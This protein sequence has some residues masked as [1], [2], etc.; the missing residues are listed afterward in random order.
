[1]DVILSTD[2]AEFVNRKVNDGLFSQASDVVSEALRQ[3][4]ERDL[5]SSL[6]GTSK[7]PWSVLGLFQGEDVGSLAFIV[8]MDAVKS[9]NED[10]KAIMAE[11]KSVTAA[12][13]QLR[14]L[15]SKISRD[16]ATNAGQIDGVPPLDFSAGMG[17]EE[18]YSNV[19][20]PFSNCTSNGGGVTIVPTNLVNGRQLVNVAQ[21]KM[22]QQ[23]LQDDLD[24]MNEMSEMTSL[25]LQMAMD[26]RSKLVET[27]SNIMKKISATGDTIVQNLK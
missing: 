26:R 7:A 20:I 10:L 22:I 11:I 12:K 25:R 6:G 2:L 14:H 1:M 16:V 3:F 9:A 19:Q 21:I 5:T 17:S 15:I 4:R 13:Q 27:L 18:A 23:E 24:S 8:M